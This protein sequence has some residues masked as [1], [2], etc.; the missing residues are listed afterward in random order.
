M[1]KLRNKSPLLT[2]NFTGKEYKVR[3]KVRNIVI[4]LIIVFII[5]INGKPVL[6]EKQVY[7][8]MFS[9]NKGLIS[10]SQINIQPNETGQVDF[11]VM[12]NSPFKV[13]LVVKTNIPATI[14]SNV[15]TL[16]QDVSYPIS[17]SYY[18]PHNETK[19]LIVSVDG[20]VI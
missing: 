15:T 5:L 1:E 14:L 9:I 13:N 2:S 11:F 10:S 6:Q 16:E 17:V 18:N 4:A 7:V 19:T 3:N 12:N 20:E 8:D